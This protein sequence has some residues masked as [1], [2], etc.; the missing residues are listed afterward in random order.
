MSSLHQRLVT[1]SALLSF[2]FGLFLAYQIGIV[3]RLFDA[4]P[5]WIPH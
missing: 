4:A 3:D 5:I 1:G 2:G